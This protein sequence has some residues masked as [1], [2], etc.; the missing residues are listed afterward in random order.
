MNPVVAVL[1]EALDA[2]TVADA[3]APVR[4]CHRYLSIAPWRW[5]DAGQPQG[6]THSAHDPSPR[7]VVSVLAG[8]W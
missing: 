6:H 5:V 1:S 7:A 2:A 8:S 3:D 4:P